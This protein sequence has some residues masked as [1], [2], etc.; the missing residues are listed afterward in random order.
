MTKIVIFSIDGTLANIDH[1]FYH[2]VRYCNCGFKH[3]P[4][5]HTDQLNI[6]AYEYYKFFK[7]RGY[8]IF[9]ITQRSEK[10]R[11]ETE[12]WLKMNNIEFDNL[13]MRQINDYRPAYLVKQDILEKYFHLEVKNSIQAVFEY[14]E[15]CVQ[16]YKLHNIRR[17][18]DCKNYQ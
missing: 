17:V 12:K 6:T 5:N 7:Q 3:V 13:E 4:N 1:R 8:T 15:S 11:F 10:Q 14:D 16:M 2:S 9:I 18:Y